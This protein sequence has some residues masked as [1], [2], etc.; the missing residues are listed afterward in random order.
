MLV[1][2]HSN[3]S[4]SGVGGLWVLRFHDAL[5]LL[6]ACVRIQ[7]KVVREGGTSNA[8]LRLIVHAQI[9]QL[10]KFCLRA[11]FTFDEKIYEQVKGKP[12][13][14]P[15]SEL[16]AEVAV[17]RLESVVF[18]H[19][20]P[21]FWARYVDDTFAIIERDEM[22]TFK[23]RL[24]SPFPEIQLTMEEEENNQ[25]AFLDVLVCRKDCCCLKNEVF[26]KAINT[27]PLL[28]YNSN[29]PISHKRS[30]VR[31]LYRRVNMHCSKPED[32]I[33]EA[34]QDT[35]SLRQTDSICFYQPVSNFQA[36][37]RDNNP[38]SSEEQRTFDDR[39][40]QIAS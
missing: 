8:I 32:K 2:L 20:R 30:S 23:E 19:H 34:P 12:V 3:A 25:L 33:V 5:W 7:L 15:I 31:T 38:P 28:N 22:L 10:L 29:D 21:K 4:P 26:R 6:P 37:F 18:Q 1:D 14:S 27:I 36:V 35:G 39:Q 16:I 40:V 13:V 9:L 11:Y 24:N 17:Q